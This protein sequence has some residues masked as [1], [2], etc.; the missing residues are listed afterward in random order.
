MAQV[1]LPFFAYY[2]D[3]SAPDIEAAAARTPAVFGDKILICG[4]DGFRW[5]SAD[6]L[7]NGEEGDAEPHERYTCPM[8]YIT[9]SGL[10][11]FVSDTAEYAD[12]DDLCV[13][14]INFVSA[15]TSPLSPS[16][17]TGMRSR[18]PPLFSVA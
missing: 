7:L 9:A 10:Q 16:L 8:C 18:A 1:F 13:K 3:L 11:S 2:G 6:E 17:W 15:F 12:T 5:V 4:A 14:N